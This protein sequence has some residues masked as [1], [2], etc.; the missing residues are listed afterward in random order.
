V[1]SGQITA[2]EGAALLGVSRNTYYKWENRALAAIADALE[3]RNQGR[4]G[5]TP[6][7]IRVQEIKEENQQLRKALEREKES[8][9]L[10]NLSWELK[11]DMI[12]RERKKK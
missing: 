4:P 6:E 11:V 12:R 3:D 8:R 1:Q 5:P 9:R 2:T 10:Q 7:E